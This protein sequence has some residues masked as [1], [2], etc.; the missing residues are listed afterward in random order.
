MYAIGDLTFWGVNALAPGSEPAPAILA[1]MLTAGVDLVLYNF[2]IVGLLEEYIFRRGLFKMMNDK[3]EKWGMS[4][5]KAF[6]LAAIGSAL[7]FSGVHYIDWGAAMAW[8]GLG[9]ATASSGLGGAYAFTWAGFVARGVLGVV[10]AWIYKRSGIILVPMIAHFWADSMEG[11][12]LVWGL[13]VFLALAA[14]ALV[15]SFFSRLKPKSS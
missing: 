14:G 6:W 2:V 9:D 10:L 12:G 11:L 1:K 3:L 8:F 4:L 7:I 15:L 5:G 13:P